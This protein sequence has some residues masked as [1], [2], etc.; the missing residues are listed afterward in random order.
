MDPISLLLAT[1]LAAAASD[2]AD[3]AR[4][5]HRGDPGRPPQDPPDPLAT[6]QEAIDLLGET[7]PER[8]TPL[9]WAWM[10]LME[11]SGTP[12]HPWTL[13]QVQ[14]FRQGQVICPLGHN[15]KEGFFRYLEMNLQ[16]SPI[17][18]EGH[19]A[20]VVDQESGE[21]DYGV[22]NGLVRCTH[23]GHSPSNNIFWFPFSGFD[24][25]YSS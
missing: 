19:D 7:W 14:A 18:P 10:E 3:Q 24:L 1:L 16:E 11:A 12:V 13:E 9:D 25:N 21:T 2:Q 20:A 15:M 4:R 23:E 8:L 6:P 5:Q 17:K 22:V